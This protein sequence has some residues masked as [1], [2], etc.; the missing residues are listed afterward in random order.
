MGGTLGTSLVERGTE[1]LTF[2]RWLPCGDEF[3]TPRLKARNDAK[4]EQAD[5]SD[6]EKKA[7]RKLVT[8]E[9]K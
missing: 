7:L 8:Q 2:S 9:F 3:T 6:D 4:T 5:L 1:I